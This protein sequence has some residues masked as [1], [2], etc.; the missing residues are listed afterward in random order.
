MITTTTLILTMTLIT[1][2]TTVL[3][4]H[5]QSNLSGQWML[6][7][8]GT[9]NKNP[10]VANAATVPWSEVWTRDF[11]GQDD[12]ALARSHKSWRP[13]CTA[14]YR[15]QRMY[16]NNIDGFAIDPYWF[17]VV[18]RILHGIV[19][20]LILPTAGYTLRLLSSDDYIGTGRTANNSRS[21]GG[22]GWSRRCRAL[23]VTALFAVHP[24]HVEAVANTTGRAEVMCAI[25]YL[26]GFCAYAR[27]GVGLSLNS[28]YSSPVGAGGKQRML[29]FHWKVSLISAVGV[30]F[31]MLCTLAS[32]LCKE[33]GVSLPIMCLIWD[34][35]IGTVTSLPELLNLL[36]HRTTS[37]NMRKQDSDSS[38]QQQQIK[39][40]IKAIRRTQCIMFILRVIACIAITL[41]LGLWRLSKNG[42]S[43]ASL[44]CE[45]NPT[46]CE[47]DTLLRIL[48]FGLIWCIN[49]WILLCPIWLAPDWSGESVPLISRPV[50]DVRFPLVV[51][52]VA[53]LGWF[54]YHAIVAAVTPIP[55]GIVPPSLS[56]K[57]G[58]SSGVASKKGKS[59]GV[60]SVMVVDYRYKD[61]EEMPSFHLWRRTVVTCFIWMLVPFMMSSNLFVYVGFVVADRTLYLPSFGF[62]LLLVECLLLLPSYLYQP[63]MTASSCEDTPKVEGS[64]PKGVSP[65][66]TNSKSS[67]SILPW[68]C[69]TIILVLYTIKQQAQTTRWADPVLLWGESYRI[70]PNSCINDSQYGMA[71]VNAN[72][73][74]DAAKVLMKGYKR[75][76]ADNRYTRRIGGSGGSSSKKTQDGSRGRGPLAKL[77][78]LSSSMTTRFKLV[79]AMGNSGDCVNARPIIEEGLTM[80][81]DAIKDIDIEMLS[82]EYRQ[83]NQNHPK[84]GS[85]TYSLEEINS[86]LKSNNAYML[87]AKSRC[88]LDI[89]SMG[90]FAFEA[91]SILP[92][93]EYAM[94]HATSVNS[95][96]ENIQSAG[97]DLRDV[98]LKQRVSADG[99][100]CTLDFVVDK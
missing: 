79:T 96:I 84:R 18:D 30:F 89:V 91:V 41:S 38:E 32:M 52:L 55:R 17:H 7:D 85:E 93:L 5:S 60:E 24:I 50:M 47:P 70:N 83:D 40:H 68:I 56:S 33:H 51:L 66:Y 72:R 42:S 87:V 23:W 69:I 35:Y 62:C 21:G 63:E 49:F 92:V 14:S 76:T 15:L 19:T 8:M 39:T 88:A 12:L 20:A 95:L 64:P 61:N 99:Q 74:K 36:F 45:Q 57:K 26:L 28:S 6:D 77:G 53:C 3:Y 43:S 29:V 1:L 27:L 75:E 65:S 78:S 71:L 82:P 98:K 54:L 44:V 9:V 2:T 81:E 73:N 25:F 100:S 46:A 59:S 16:D 48:N 67:T 10:V 37:H 80:I 94:N 22:S 31:M 11:W 4:C 97:L 90:Q 86:T 13:L 34:A 58:K